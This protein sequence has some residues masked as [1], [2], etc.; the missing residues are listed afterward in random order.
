[1]EL[2]DDKVIELFE[3]LGGISV[4]VENLSNNVDTLKSI[5]TNGL[6]SKVQAIEMCVETMD[7]KISTL[8]SAHSDKNKEQALDI[9]SETWVWTKRNSPKIMVVLVVWFFWK[10]FIFMEPTFVTK[11]IDLVK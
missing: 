10:T 4:S 6:S 5:V 11:I 3:K 7:Q 2:S 9:L 1:M 8:E